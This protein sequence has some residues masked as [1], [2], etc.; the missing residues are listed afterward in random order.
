ME[1]LA[2]E[3]LIGVA[4]VGSLRDEIAPGHL[5]VPDQFIDRTHRRISTFFGHG[6]VPHI[7]FADPVCPVLSG[8]LVDAGRRIGATMHPNGTYVCMEG[9]QFSTRAE[10]FL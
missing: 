5:V 4:S 3:W 1:R 9:P 8:T 10:S 2:V 6:I 7:S